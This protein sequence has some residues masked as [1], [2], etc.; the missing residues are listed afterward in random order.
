MSPSRSVSTW[1][2]ARQRPPAFGND[3][4]SE[5]HRE[6]D[7]L[8]WIARRTSHIPERG[9]QLVHSYGAYSN[10][11]R[12]S[13]ARGEAIEVETAAAESPAD[14][15]KSEY[16]WLKERRKSWARLMRRVYEA[17]PLPCRCGQRMHVVGFI[18]QVPVI[19][20]I[21]NHVDRR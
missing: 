12:G 6:H 17:D 2:G 3:S 13:A 19:R 9:A 8:E 18:T 20:K 4:I 1:C 21:L 11:H 15:T 7:Y 16:A 14:P 5:G 10:A